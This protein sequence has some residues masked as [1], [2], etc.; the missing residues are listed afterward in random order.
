MQMKDLPDMTLEEQ[1]ELEAEKQR[2]REIQYL[3]IKLNS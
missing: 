1:K 2:L 3:S